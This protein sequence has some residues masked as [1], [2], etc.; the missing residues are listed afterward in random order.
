MDLVDDIPHVN[1]QSQILP[2]Q[3]AVKQAVIQQA[4]TVPA[5]EVPQQLPKQFLLETRTLTRPDIL[6]SGKQESR[7][8]DILVIDK[9]EK[10]EPASAFA[11]TFRLNMLGTNTGIEIPLR[12]ISYGEYED[13][14]TS[15]EFPQR[16][17]NQNPEIQDRYQTEFQKVLTKRHVRIFETAT[18]Q[19][20]PGEKLD[21]KCEW[22]KQLGVGESNA[23]YDYISDVASA[24][25]VGSLKSDYD[26]MTPTGCNALKFTNFNDLLSA[27]RIGS[28]FIFHRPFEK[29]LIEFPLKQISEK[30]KQQIDEE[31]K[32]PIPPGRPGQNP[33]TG[34]L[35]ADF[36]RNEKDPGYI[37]SMRAMARKRT[38]MRLNA[39]LQFEIP[40]DS[41][42]EKYKWISQRL[43]GD[44]FH[45]QLFMER[46]LFSYRSRLDFF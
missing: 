33:A 28:R 37:R 8:F 9:P 42:E 12:G 10:W 1:Q 32:D 6:D 13:M 25:E 14:E 30:T 26:S 16:P 18:G 24:L 46:E 3:Q 15:F 38:V 4:V 20:I 2:V 40:G 27:S 44:I 31:C 7:D 11:T 34:K 39:I 41:I 23:I 29:F 45:L 43:V 19:S 35:E 22:L 5:Q 36:I 17:D 21:D